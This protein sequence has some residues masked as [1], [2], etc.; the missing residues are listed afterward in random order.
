MRAGSYNID[1]GFQSQ[2]VILQQ[3]NSQTGVHTAE[4]DKKRSQ[5]G[6]PSNNNSLIHNKAGSSLSQ[7]NSI[8]QINHI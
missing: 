1:K 5:K 8:N 3:T 2:H 4:T 6:K 7:Q